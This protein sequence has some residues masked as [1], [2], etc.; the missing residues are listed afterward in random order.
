MSRGQFEAVSPSAK[1]GPLL[2]NDGT[3]PGDLDD[4]PGIDD[5][6]EVMEE[7]DEVP[8]PPEPEFEVPSRP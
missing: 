2:A 4:D 1:L 7:M 6:D 8:P 5:F 3:A